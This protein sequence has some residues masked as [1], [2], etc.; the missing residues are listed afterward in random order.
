[1]SGLRDDS[2]LVLLGAGAS[3]ESGIPHS[4]DMIDKIE[5]RI[6]ENQE[7]WARFESLYNYIRSA[8]FYSE[9]I[10]GIFET[11]V[12]YNIEKLVDILNEISERNQHALY[13][14]VGAWNPALVDVAGKEFHLVKEFRDEIVRI[15]TTEWLAVKDYANSARYYSGLLALRRSLDFPLR[16]FSLNYD[17]CVE[18]AASCSDVI[19]ERGFDE[20]RMWEWRLFDHNPD[21]PK[22]IYLYKLHGSMDWTYEN[23]QLTFH[24]DWSGITDAALIFGTSYKL[25]Y[26]DPFL[27]LSY[28]FRRWALESQII[29]V[30]GYGFGDEHINTFM[31]QALQSDTKRILV[32]VAPGETICCDKRRQEIADSIEYKNSRQIVVE[33][34]PASEFMTNHLTASKLLEYLPDEDD[35]LFSELRNS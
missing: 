34:F 3:V 23:D 32:A 29:V 6:R 18:K 24:D 5:K 2:I 25:E 26:R 16:V 19:V 30:I 13:P 10:H 35:N 31:R 15:L 22:D 8:I 27:F 1:M 9:G 21:D 4:S 14:F 12:N 28:E 33:S 20:N 11:A 17:L 7:G